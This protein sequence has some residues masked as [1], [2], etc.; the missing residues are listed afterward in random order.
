LPGIFINYRREDSG[1]YAQQIY[2]AMRSYFGAKFVF[3]DIDTIR[4]GED[5]RSIIQQSIAESDVFLSIIGRTWLRSADDKGVQRLSYP[6]DLVRLEIAQA[7]KANLHVVPVLVGRAQMPCAA[8][9]PEDMKALASRNAHEIPDRFFDQSVRQLIQTIRPHVRGG[10]AISRRKVLRLALGAAGTFGGIIVLS[11]LKSP[12]ESRSDEKKRQA[13][14]AIQKKYEVFD[15]M[16]DRKTG[17]A[18][19]VVRKPSNIQELP[20]EISGPWKIDHINF[21]KAVSIPRVE[22]KAIWV[23]HPTIG[24]FWTIVGF[25]PDRTL[26]VHANESRVISGIRDGVEQWAFQAGAVHG[27]TP[28]GR[29]WLNAQNMY[30]SERDNLACY[31]SRGEGG[32]LPSSAK[33]PSDL[34]RLTYSSDLQ[35]PGACDGGVVNLNSSKAAISVD[36]NC[37]SWGVVQDDRGRFYASTDRGT[38]YCFEKSGKILWTWKSGTPTVSPPDFS[39]EDTVFSTDDRLVCLREGTIR[40]TLPLESPGVGITDKTGAM[41]VATTSPGMLGYHSHSITNLIDH[42]GRLF[43]SLPLPGSPGIPDPDGRLYVQDNSANFILCLA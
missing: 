6:T 37:S 40:W 22:P 39:L 19:V 38:V 5:F 15:A 4:S 34:I 9:L 31:N 8:D 35:K 7:L 25:A 23:A 3:M 26:F 12:P 43:W 16:I 28:G 10:D 32:L 41:T 42:D 27:I 33:L 18:P 17:Q 11:I 24:E 21:A 29:I 20:P 13:A 14:E 30:A 1:G 2:R 36:G